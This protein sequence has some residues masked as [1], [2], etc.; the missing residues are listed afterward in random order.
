MTRTILMRVAL[1]VLVIAA[2]EPKDQTVVQPVA[3]ADANP[4]RY[5]VT[6]WDSRT[7][8]ETVLLVHVN[9]RGDVDSTQ[10]DIGSGHVA[11]DS[12]ATTG[13]KKLRF[14]PGKRGERYV[15]MWTRIPIRFS[16]D[17]TATVGVPVAPDSVQ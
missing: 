3:M 16:L 14:T 8:G 4:V 2:C 9:E 1:T 12:A 17:S 7:E 15:A 5:P 11:F 13:A 10:V 6:L